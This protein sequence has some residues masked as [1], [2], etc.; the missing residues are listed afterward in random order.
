[1]IITNIKLILKAD[2][3][4]RIKFMDLRRF[5]HKPVQVRKFEKKTFSTIIDF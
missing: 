5:F 4:E 2:Y 3:L 1:M